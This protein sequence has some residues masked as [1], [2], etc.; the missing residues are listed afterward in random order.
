AS[1]DAHTGFLVVRLLRAQPERGGCGE[2]PN[3]SDP[4]VDI[5]HPETVRHSGEQCEIGVEPLLYADMPSPVALLGVEGEPFEI[6][7]RP[8]WSIEVECIA[9]LQFGGLLAHTS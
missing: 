4:F 2:G 8:A 6:E 7:N 5:R 9:R 1:R 3:H